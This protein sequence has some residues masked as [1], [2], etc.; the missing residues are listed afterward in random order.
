MIKLLKNFRSPNSADNADVRYS[1]DEPFI[2]Y[3]LSEDGERYELY[4]PYDEATVSADSYAD[5]DYVAIP[6]TSTDC[7][8]VPFQR[9]LPFQNVCGSSFDH[10]HPKRRRDEARSWIQLMRNK[11]CHPTDH[12]CTDGNYYDQYGRAFLHDCH[13]RM[14]GGHILIG[15]HKDPIVKPDGKVYLLPI[16]NTHNITN[17]GS[18]AGLGYYMILG[19]DCDGL[20]LFGYL[21]RSQVEEAIQ[22]E[23]AAEAAATTD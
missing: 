13:G 22:A 21:Q 10:W 20:E 16:C 5:G 6:L 9:G 14:V 8:V 15:K 11:G 4:E 1:E 3:K 18:G 12:C 17:I 7:N 2:V 23:A 19:E